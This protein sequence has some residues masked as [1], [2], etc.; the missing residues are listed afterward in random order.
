MLTC[1]CRGNPDEEADD[2]EEATRI[3]QLK[4]DISALKTEEQRIGQLTEV[5]QNMLRVMSEDR[6]CKEYHLV[7]YC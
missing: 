4:E 2:S 5:A 6:Q 7:V 3:R 1:A